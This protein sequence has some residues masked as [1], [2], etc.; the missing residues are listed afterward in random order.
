V[1]SK[2]PLET[3]VRLPLID[4]GLTPDALQY[5]IT[6]EG[7][8]I[9][10]LDM[11][12]LKEKVAVEADGR[13]PHSQPGQFVWDRRRLNQLQALGW[14]VVIFTWADTYRPRYIAN[15]VADAL[16]TARKRIAV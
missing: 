11:A 9:A 7:I 6:I 2:T 14:T 12:F 10:E 13:D 5:P 8:L 1:R 3:R 4:N 16:S 15:T